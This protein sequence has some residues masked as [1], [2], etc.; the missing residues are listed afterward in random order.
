[1]INGELFPEIDPYAIRQ[2]RVPVLIMSGGVSYAFLQYIDQELVR[3]IPG[4]ESVVYPDA[5]HKMWFKYPQLCRDDA[6][7]FFLRHP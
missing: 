7:A 1:M 2:I 6:M 5:G 3:L 4:A